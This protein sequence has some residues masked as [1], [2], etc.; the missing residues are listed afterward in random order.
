MRDKLDSICDAKLVRNFPASFPNV[1]H[2]PVQAAKPL[3]S[4]AQH[5]Q[6]CHRTR[7]MGSW[8]AISDLW[9][10]TWVLVGGHPQTTGT[11][12]NG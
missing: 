11:Y 3:T 6:V 7:H 4:L 2:A 12:T 8:E 1:S 10:S 9:Q 5:A